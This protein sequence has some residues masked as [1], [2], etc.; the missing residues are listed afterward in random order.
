MPK[1]KNKQ[2]NRQEEVEDDDDTHSVSSQ[3]SHG[4]SRG[5]IQPQNAVVIEQNENGDINSNNIIHELSSYLEALSEKRATAREE[6]LV[7]LNKAFS[8]S[9]MNEFID[10]SRE[11]LAMAIKNCIRKGGNAEV[12]LAVK[13]LALL[14]VTLGVESEKEFNEFH[15]LLAT[16]ITDRSDSNVITNAIE[17]LSIC[18][19]IACQDESI[20]YEHL[21]LFEIIF[22]HHKYDPI[23]KVA[24]LNAWGLLITVTSVPYI[25]SF[26]FYA[27]MPK[28]VELLKD[29]DVDVRVTAG[30]VIAL[31]FQIQQSEDENCAFIPENMDLTELYEI[32]QKLS[33]DSNRHKSKKDKQKQKSSFREIRNTIEDGKAIEEILTVNGSRFMFTTWRHLFQLNAFRNC[34]NTGFHVHFSENPLFDQVFKGVKLMSRAEV[35]TGADVRKFFSPNSIANKERAQDRDKQRVKKDVVHYQL[36][37]DFE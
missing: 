2:K 31:L 18:S 24:A 25:K 20:V 23:V 11:T 7:L 12:A 1:G 8:N 36:D 33:N 5:E 13:T 34:L 26:L 4:S 14:C 28:L 9:I 37:S 21:K 22:H 27:Q 10:S 15:A 29:E 6:N 16:I 32:L 19:F 3:G 35:T 30:E 17:A